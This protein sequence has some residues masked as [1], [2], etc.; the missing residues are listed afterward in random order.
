MTRTPHDA[1]H[2]PQPGD[3]VAQREV[4]LRHGDRLVY[5]PPSHAYKVQTSVSVWR[6]WAPGVDRVAGSAG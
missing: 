4:I 3:I 1:Q 2:D 6:T 5:W